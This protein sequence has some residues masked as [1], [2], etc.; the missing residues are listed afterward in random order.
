MENNK[1]DFMKNRP[2]AA[3]ANLIK[4]NYEMH[5]QKNINILTVIL[6]IILLAISIIC[7][8]KKAFFVGGIIFFIF[9]CLIISTIVSCRSKKANA[10]VE[11]TNHP[12]SIFKDIE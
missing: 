1:K 2:V 12:D 7:F 4:D 3:S 11:P 10:P 6:S 9:V 8:V 5:P